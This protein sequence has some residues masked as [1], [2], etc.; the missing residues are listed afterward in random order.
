MPTVHLK[1]GEVVEVPVEDLADYLEENE[2]KIQLQ[3][4]KSRRDPIARKLQQKTIP[5]PNCTKLPLR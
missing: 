4:L 3:K 1:T 2:D 5:L